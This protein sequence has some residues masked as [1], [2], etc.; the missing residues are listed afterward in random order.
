LAAPP[1]PRADRYGD[2][3]PEGAVARL[4]SA[5]LRHAGLS[6]YVRLPGGKTVLTV[7]SDR[8][9]RWWDLASGRQVRAVQL[10]GKAG[11]GHRVTLSPDG[12]TLVAHDG[13]QLVFWAADSGKELKTVPAPPRRVNYLY[14]SPDGKTLLVGR[15]DYRVT[16]WKWEAGKQ[17]EVR[18]PVVPRPMIQFNSDSSTHGGFSPDGKWFVA[19]AN[20]LEP[21]GVFDLATGR[22]VHRLACHATVSAV[23]PDSKVLAA[24]CWEQDK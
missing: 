5:R 14:F 1:A 23:S 9:L 21:L 2:P 22:E 16:L 6:D 19:G 4:G 8:V 17:R 7:G 15:E 13:G 18:V 3:L 11:L 20:S 10:R 24:S 12:K